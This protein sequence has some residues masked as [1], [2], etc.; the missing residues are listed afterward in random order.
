MLHIRGARTVVLRL[1][2]ATSFRG[3]DRNPAQSGA[4][5]V[6]VCRR[7][8]RDAAEKSFEELRTRHEADHRALFAKASL[9]LPGDADSLLPTDV[10]LRRFQEGN[11]DHALAALLFHYGRYLM[12]ASSRAGT[13][14]ANLQG[15]WNRERRPPWSSNYTTNINLQMN[16]WPLETCNLGDLGEPLFRFVEEIAQTGAETARVQFGCGGWTANHNVDLWRSTIPVGGSA[17][18]AY[19]PMGGAWL[20]RHL[21]DHYLFTRDRAWLANVAYPLMEGAARFQLDWLVEGPEGGLVTSPSTSPENA[22][23]TPEGEV[24]CVSMG[25][26][27]DMT[28]VRELFVASLEAARILGLRTPLHD[29]MREALPRLLPFA[30]GA[31]GQLLEWCRDF[32]E[33]EIHHRHVSHLY[34][35]YPGDQISPDT[36]P[37]LAQACR[38]SLERR[39][40]DGTGWSLAW[41]VCLWARLWDGNHA[42]R[43]IRRQ[44][45][46][47]FS[48]ETDYGG[49]GG[50]YPNLM[51]AHPPFQIDG[52]FGVA[53]GIAE[54]L[55]QSHGE[56]LHVLP[57][58]PDAWERGW[59]NGLRARGNLEVDMAWEAGSLTRLLIRAGQE[60]TVLV[61]M[62]GDIRQHALH[63]GENELL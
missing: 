13:Q 27:M 23:R 17:R 8:I 53:A 60:R 38:T 48:T 25:S 5:P 4:D 32:P 15:I 6:P 63:A 14:P 12:I 59:V 28:I 10:R 16:Y 35:L 62:G 36:T 37:A 43:L 29:R 57:A 7:R 61:R 19:W 55:L 9:E 2:A 44:L 11:G 31:E 39:G 58:L 49:G 41:K 20:C 18:Y 47:V 50:T 22:F 40:D 21:W 56:V 42:W 30:V 24:C 1:A 45:R 34:G 52:N 26:T 51:D 46:P 54:M 3:Y 33:D